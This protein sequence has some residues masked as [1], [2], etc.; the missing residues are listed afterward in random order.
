LKS[1]SKCY[2]KERREESRRQRTR[3]TERL[4]GMEGKDI[5]FGKLY[6]FRKIKESYLKTREKR[7]VS[8]AG[9]VGCG[10]NVIIII[11]NTER[12]DMST[13][14]ALSASTHLFALGIK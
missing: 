14:S 3:I 2:G 6:C 8:S 9:C 10:A 11:I 4:S 1:E 7:V 13:V 5:A 12:T